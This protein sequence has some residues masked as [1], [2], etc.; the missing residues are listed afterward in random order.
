MEWKLLNAGEI[1][2]IYREHMVADFPPT[3]LK[4]ITAIHRMMAQGRYD[5]WGIYEADKR[6]LIGYACLA[7]AGERSTPLLDYL[8]VVPGQRN[9]SWGSRILDQLVRQYTGRAQFLCIESEYPPSAPDPVIAARRL[10]FYRR[11]GAV[12]PGVDSTVYGVRYC[13]FALPV[14]KTPT[15]GQLCEALREVYR[16]MLAPEQYEKNVVIRTAEKERDE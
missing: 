5:A 13:N 15:A 16:F 14:S 7:L 2:Q 4:P 9:R 6:E 10:E 12:Q 1:A 8:A 3:E 11:A